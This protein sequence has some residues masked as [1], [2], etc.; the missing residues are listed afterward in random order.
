MPTARFVLCLAKRAFGPS[1]AM[2]GPAGVPGGLS[3]LSG[4]SQIQRPV[5]ARHPHRFGDFTLGCMVILP[6]VAVLDS[7]SL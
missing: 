4:L 1:E 2:R 7:V 3:L 6:W 5:I